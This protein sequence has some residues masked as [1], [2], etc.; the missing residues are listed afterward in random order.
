MV[1]DIFPLLPRVKKMLHYE[2]LMTFGSCWNA[3]MENKSISFSFI[4]MLDC[5]IGIKKFIVMK[6]PNP[7][8][9][10][11]LILPFYVGL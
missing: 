7:I 10:R 8:F 3:G 9:T 5:F 6:I 4:N 1:S 11:I 2:M